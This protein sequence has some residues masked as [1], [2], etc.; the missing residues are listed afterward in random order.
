LRL[1]TCPLNQSIIVILESKDVLFDELA[2]LWLDRQHYNT[3]HYIYYVHIVELQV[4]N[5]VDIFLPMMLKTM[6]H[7]KEVDGNLVDV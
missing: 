7:T 6:D 2:N 1:E 3:V 4:L 5:N